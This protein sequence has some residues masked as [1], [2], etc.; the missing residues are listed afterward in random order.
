MISLRKIYK[1]TIQVVKADGAKIK[2]TFI[3]ELLIKLAN[4]PKTK[5]SSMLTDR[6]NGNPIELGA[7]NGII[8]K[9]LT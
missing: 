5:G 2:H 1:E 8:S 6:L 4:Y 3:D 9:L 7:K